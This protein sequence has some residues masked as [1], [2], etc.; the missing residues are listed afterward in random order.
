M[1]D[2]WR[3]A[4]AL[5]Q[6]R[7]MVTCPLCGALVSTTDGY[8]IHKG[9]HDAMNTWVQQIADNFQLIFNY[10]TNPDT[11]LEKRLADLISAATDS[12]TSLRADATTA[13][14]TTNQ[15]VSQLRTDATNAITGLS[16]RT[17]TIETEVTKNP[18]GIWARL[19]ALET[20]ANLPVVNVKS[21]E[22]KEN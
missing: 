19:A 17:T 20:V 3:T 12:I 18:G 5:K 21:L 6:L 1:A 13:I 10:V 22:A 9:W 14:T 2:D 11:G 16:T 8:G 4:E 7:Q 15:S